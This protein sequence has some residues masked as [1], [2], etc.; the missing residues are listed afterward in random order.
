MEEKW[1]K[2]NNSTYEISNY[3]LVRNLRKGR[4]IIIKPQIHMKGY[5]KIGSSRGKGLKKTYVHRLVALF[6]IPNPEK[7]PYV[8]HKNA[9]KTDNYVG[10]LEWCTMEENNE[11]QKLNGLGNVPMPCVVINLKN[12]IIA[13]YSSQKK[14]IETHRGQ[15]GLFRIEKDLY[16]V[17]Y[18]EYLIKN[19]YKWQ[20][21]SRLEKGYPFA[22]ASTCAA[23]IDR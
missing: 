8:T 7:K 13:E 15:R 21:Q 3:G 12:E 2:I 23:V 1:V 19:R 6:F 9:I 18:G 10:N 22:K 5:L 16:T 11:H 17:E 14:A 4:Y 20:K